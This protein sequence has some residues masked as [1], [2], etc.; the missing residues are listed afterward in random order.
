MPDLRDILA[1]AYYWTT[2]PW[3][4]AW[5]RQAAAALRAPVMVLYYHRIADDRATPWTL[6]HR[7]FFDQL[8]WLRDRFDMISLDEARRRIVS[9]NRRPAISI[10][11]DD[12][13]AD[14]SFSAIPWMIERHIPCTYFVTLKNLLTGEPFEHDRR[15]GYRFRPNTVGQICEMAEAGIEIGGHTYS[16]PCLGGTPDE[17]VL[18]REIVAARSELERL[19][20]YPVRY[21]AFPFGQRK[22]LSAAAFSAA[23]QAGFDAVCSAYGGYNFPGDDPFHLQRIAVDQRFSRLRNW[24]TADPRK[25]RTPRFD[26]GTSAADQALAVE[27]AVSC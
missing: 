18:D 27:E 14:N 19:L 2:R 26:L 4:S 6:D 11:F 25:L 22:N 23:R 5:N 13:Y 12:G 9:G 10:T 20:N 3:R 16:H 1:G 17:A 8:N 24:V 7:T 15:L 21:F